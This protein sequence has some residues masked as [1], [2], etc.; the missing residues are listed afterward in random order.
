M[1][2]SKRTNS[3][4]D[5]VLGRAYVFLILIAILGLW[6]MFQFSPLA[7][8]L[9]ILPSI[10]LSLLI[11]HLFNKLDVLKKEIQEINQKLDRLGKND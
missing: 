1:E 2:Q 8:F 11:I 7:V 10:G 9:F 3:S 4:D 6:L 5:A